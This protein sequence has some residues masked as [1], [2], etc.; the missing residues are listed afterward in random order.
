MV[1][2]GVYG[3]IPYLPSNATSD[4]Q[5]HLRNYSLL[6]H[7]F[8]LTVSSFSSQQLQHITHTL[9]IVM[10]PRVR[11]VHGVW[12]VAGQLT[13]REW[14]CWAVAVSAM[15]YTAAL[16]G[17]RLGQKKDAV[18]FCEDDCANLN[19]RVMWMPSHARQRYQRRWHTKNTP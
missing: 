11:V 8:L 9:N 12:K 14:S 7:V 17:Q 5:L 10:N 6:P 2:Y 16:E 18:T 15:T 13:P 1:G 19:N 3:A 4:F